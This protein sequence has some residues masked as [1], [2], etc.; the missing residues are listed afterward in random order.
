M[1][2]GWYSTL[3]QEHVDLDTNGI[4]RIVPEGV[5]TTDGRTIELDVLILATG[6]HAGKFLW[7][8]DVVGRSGAILHDRWEGGENPRAYLG[9]TVPDFPNL[10]CLYGPNT[11]P[12]VGSVIYMLEC[13]TSYILACLR[14]MI[15]NGH[16]AI[17][18]RG[19]V[20]DEF[21]DRLD[22]QMETMVWRHPKVKSYYNNSQDA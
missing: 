11:N 2:N 16:R 17:D 19:E 9:I 4:E 12:V 22:T 6:F 20:H 14:E 7:P 13:Q 10:F 3:V 21:N 8:M 15:E 1:D 5:I 18:C